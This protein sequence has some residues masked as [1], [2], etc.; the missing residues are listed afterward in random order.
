MHPPLPRGSVIPV[1]ET[2]NYQ[3]QLSMSMEGYP[4]QAPKA[5]CCFKAGR[6]QDPMVGPGD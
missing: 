3:A 4:A 2:S 1:L 6:W 5:T